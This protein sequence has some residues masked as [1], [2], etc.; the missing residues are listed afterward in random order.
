MQHIGIYMNNG[1]S[2]SPQVHHKFDPPERNEINGSAIVNRVIGRNAHQRHKEFK[3]FFSCCN[4][5]VLTPS[6]KEQPNWKCSSFF[7]H[8]I[9]VSQSAI[10]I[11]KY[12]SCDEQTIG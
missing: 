12:L 10:F 6:R 2:P 7:P 8:T 1:L 9:Y 4:L 5:A 11:G 3:A